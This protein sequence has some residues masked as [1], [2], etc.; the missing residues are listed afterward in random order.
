MI[1]LVPPPLLY[2]RRFGLRL[3]YSHAT[4][5]RA[6]LIARILFRHLR[7]WLLHAAR[8]PHYRHVS[9]DLRLPCLRACL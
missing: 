7:C 1:T 5:T 9:S 2:Y 3:D 6:F 8:S 4:L